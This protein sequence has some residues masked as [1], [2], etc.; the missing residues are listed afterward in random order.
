MSDTTRIDTYISSYGSML[1]RDAHK[2]LPKKVH[3]SKCLFCQHPHDGIAVIK[4]NSYASHEYG[5]ML[6]IFMCD[7]CASKIVPMENT[8]EG[9]SLR[10][11]MFS[12]E[13]KHYSRDRVK[14][15]G[16]Y[17]FDSSV[18]DHYLHGN[19]NLFPLQKRCYACKK[20]VPTDNK[21]RILVPTDNGDKLSGGLVHV[22]RYCA[23][24]AAFKK[25][26]KDDLVYLFPYGLDHLNKISND[27]CAVCHK[28]YPITNN[29][30]SYRQSNKSTGHH[31]C[32]TCTYKRVYESEK[33]ALLS[34]W[35]GRDLTRFSYASCEYC[36]QDI[37][38]DLT[39]SR[40]SLMSTII[41]K[42]RKRICP[43]C[44]KYGP[45]PVFVL[46]LG[47]VRFRVYRTGLNSY[48]VNK[49][50]LYD[51]LLVSW[52]YEGHIADLHFELSTSIPIQLDL[53]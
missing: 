23:S 7:E 38:I 12:D 3:C 39:L 28:T 10:N 5:E 41:S 1:P 44:H 45:Y 18:H 2:Y 11:N 32:P 9:D 6:D 36:E 43:S 25:H 16:D 50:T 24:H 22:C 29:E 8:F 35:A 47:D 17:K 53:L 19:I 52:P 46:K 37:C 33:D 40:R 14:M 13:E 48:K 49:F 42:E 51:K 34:D 20:D 26:T 30:R 21:Y 4:F 31:M 27:K 15:F